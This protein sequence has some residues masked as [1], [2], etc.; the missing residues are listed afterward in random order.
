M[1]QTTP[2]RR[3]SSRQAVAAAVMLAAAA[4]WLPVTA[5]AGDNPFPSLV[6]TWSGTG[7]AE[8]DSGKTESM[9]CKAY[10]T[11]DGPDGLGVAIRCANASSNIDLRAK[12]TYANGSVSGNWEERT[13]NAAG[14]VAGKASAN[15]VNLS[16]TGG[17]LTASMAV[18]INGS[19]HSVS[20][21]TKGTG[22]KGVNISLS[23]G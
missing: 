10:Y 23:R 19:S 8:L 2:I 16:I 22:L 20:I 1:L 17:G 15:K 9:R 14:S 4:V 6:G 11:G 18:S 5:R 12:L 7:Q 21:S 3:R 13:Y